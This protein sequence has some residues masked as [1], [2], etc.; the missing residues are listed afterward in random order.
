MKK[1]L[2]MLLVLALA[3]L[4]FAGGT[5]EANTTAAT[6]ASTGPLKLK[7]LGRQRSGIT[8]EETKK[9]DSWPYLCNL[10]AE[11]NLELDYT[12]VERDQYPAIL[13]AT[14]SSK[15]LPDFFYAASLS[16]ADCVNLIE[17]G[18]LMNIDDALQYSN[19]TAKAAFAEG[20]LY[21]VSR[22]LN[23]YTDGG[24]YFFGNVSKQISVENET[25]GP[26]AIIGNNCT[27]LIRQDWLDKLGLDMPTTI[28]EFFDVLVAFQENDMNGNGLKDE[29]LCINVMGSDSRG[30]QYSDSMFNGVA[31]W[32]GLAP[33]NY[34]LD[35][36][37]DLAMVPILQPGYTAYI[38]FIKKCVEAGVIHLADV[39]SYYNGGTDEGSALSK[40]MQEDAVAAYFGVALADHAY[41]SETAVYRSMPTLKTVDGVKPLQN[42][43]SGYKAWSRWAFTKNADPR[44]VAAFLDTICTQD[45]AKFI[46]FGIEGETYKIDSESG[47]YIFTASNKTDDIKATGK[48][49]GY[50]LVIDSYLPDA[51]QIGWYQE[52]YGPLNWASY[53]EFLNSRYFTEKVQNEYKPNQIEN[54]KIVCDNASK[55]Q[56]VNF[57]NDL[58][59]IAPMNTME[60][61]DIL[62]MYNADLETRM[63]ELT[64]GFI[65][66]Q[67]D[68]NKLS[69]YIDELNAI[70]L[71]EVLGV[72]QA[73]YDRRK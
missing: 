25:F 15:D 64:S 56:L 35:R 53:D 66:G 54:L 43:S 29:R 24:M 21:Y 9:T 20:G 51:S 3:G 61:A 60:E 72:R 5:K 22:Q 68:I 19:G 52:Y 49:R 67:Y 26:N 18:L 32:F 46:T 27:M 55:T 41:Q 7:V 48:A 62:D 38:N 4:A 40:A 33:F 28:D 12:V 44:A 30:T 65:T 47:Y 37:T 36:A 70:G 10:F 58:E 2:V 31:Q 11:N 13:Q 23:T 42:A 34:S 63:A 8:F 50:M 14:L 69:S 59:M 71:Q 16:T 1:L 57:N 73:Q 17:T 6:E 39:V 45:Y